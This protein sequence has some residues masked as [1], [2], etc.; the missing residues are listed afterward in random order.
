LYSAKPKIIHVSDVEG[1]KTSDALFWY[2]VDVV[3]DSVSLAMN[4]YVEFAPPPV[5]V[6]ESA[7]SSVSGV[8]WLS[9]TR[10]VKFEVP[11]AVGVP[12]IVP[13]DEPSESPEGR[14]P[15][16]IDQLYGVTPPVATTVWL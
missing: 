2:D 8:P 13:L 11:E 1:V 10:T 16:T 15:L 9:V 3:V 12:L 6:I 4:S 14:E 5:T 7:W